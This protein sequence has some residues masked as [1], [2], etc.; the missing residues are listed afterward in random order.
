M[1]LGA[2]DDPLFQ[3][4]QRPTN[5]CETDHTYDAY[6]RNVGPEYDRVVSS[7]EQSATTY[8]ECTPSEGPSKRTYRNENDD[9]SDCADQDGVI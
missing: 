3:S 5:E 9:Q 1:R 7:P 6:S 2:S 8:P 4:R